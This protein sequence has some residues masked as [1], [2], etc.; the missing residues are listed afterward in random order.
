VNVGAGDWGGSASILLDTN[1]QPNGYGG[2]VNRS[3][4]SIPVTA[5]VTRSTTYTLSD[6]L[7][8]ITKF[9]A[10]IWYGVDLDE[11]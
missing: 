8:P 9:I 1:N 11:Q 7:A 2:T 6:G 4:L 5:E 3:P 10:E